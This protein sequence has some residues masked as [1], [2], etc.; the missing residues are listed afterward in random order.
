MFALNDEKIKS[1]KAKAG[2]K[3][4]IG[5]SYDGKSILFLLI[6]EAGNEKLLIESEFI[7]LV[8]TQFNVMAF[9]PVLLPKIKQHDEFKKMR[10]GI[11]AGND[12]IL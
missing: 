1:L 4:V 10:A 3:K 8:L 5:K 11:L 2:I 9:K 6:Y 7:D 12:L